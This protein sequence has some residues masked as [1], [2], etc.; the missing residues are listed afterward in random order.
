MIPLAAWTRVVVVVPPQLWA[1]LVCLAP[2][3]P[4]VVIE[5]ATQ[6][7]LLERSDRRDR[8]RRNQMPLPNAILLIPTRS[9]HLRKHRSAM[10]HR[11]C[12]TRKP[13]IEISKTSHTDAMMVPPG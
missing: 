10:A 6:G 11:S 5:S 1:P 8:M 4:V 7:P 13:G 9:E 12:L 3:K 2:H